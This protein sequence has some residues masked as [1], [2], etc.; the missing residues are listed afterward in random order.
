MS[1]IHRI[2][3][4]FGWNT[5][6]KSIHPFWIRF[7]NKIKLISQIFK[8]ASLGLINSIRMLLF[9]FNLK[10]NQIRLK[11]IPSQKY[12][13]DL[14]D[15]RFDGIFK[16]VMHGGSKR[17]FTVH[18]ARRHIDA[19]DLSNAFVTSKM[20]FVFIFASCVQNDSSPKNDLSFHGSFIV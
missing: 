19:S 15:A 4:N 6:N 8:I 12:Q 7:G 11:G 3:I 16:S 14:I 13:I 18:N 17:K 2:P 1:R 5:W 20:V 9:C 10:I